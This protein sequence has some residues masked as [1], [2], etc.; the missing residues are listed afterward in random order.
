MNYFYVRIFTNTLLLQLG[1]NLQFS[2]FSDNDAAV[3][4]KLDRSRKMRCCCL[5]SDEASAAHTTHGRRIEE[6]K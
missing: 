1:E 5:K 6:L 3:D 2:I 4:W